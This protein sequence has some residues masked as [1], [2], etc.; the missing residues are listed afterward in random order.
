L[1]ARAVILCGTA[2]GSF[3]ARSRLV[4][5]NK[6][7]MVEREEIG[8]RSEKSSATSVH[9]ASSAVKIEDLEVC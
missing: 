6:P 1:I 8:M 2:S 3:G 4:S 9:S 5:F 7:F